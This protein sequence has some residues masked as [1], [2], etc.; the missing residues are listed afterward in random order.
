MNKNPRQISLLGS[1]A[2][3]VL[4]VTLVLTV[5]GLCMTLAFALR[6]AT[7]AIG[8]DTTIMITLSPDEDPVTSSEYKRMFNDAPWVTRYDFTDRTTVLTRENE[9]LDSITRQ[10][11]QL[12]TSNPFGDEFVLYINDGWRSADSLYVLTNRLK[13]LDGVDIVSGESVALGKVNTGM[14]RVLVYSSILA[15]VLLVISVALI[16]NTISL[17]IYS[18]R[19]NIHTMKLVGATDAFIRR[20]FVRAGL[21]TGLTAGLI[22]AGVVCAVQFYLMLSDNLVGQWITPGLIGLSAIVLVVLGAL[23][24][25]AAAWCAATNYLRKSYDALFR[26]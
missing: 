21:V 16:N 5:I 7:E 25:R 22:A 10:G 4:S 19:F 3:S 18:R 9:S 14:E 12:L 15:L 6:N 23:I 26:Q 17:S 24:A 2:T 13:N 11:L 8:E 20:P 1:R